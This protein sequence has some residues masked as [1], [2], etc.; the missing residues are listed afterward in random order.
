VHP[1]RQLGHWGEERA[2]AWYLKRGY[3]VI[4]RNWR[5]AQG[6]IDLL[7][8]RDG[9]LV[10]C[11]VKTRRTDH[12]GSPAEAVTR[13]KQ[14]RLRRLATAYLQV[15]PGGYDEIRFDVASVLGT[16]VTVVEG[17]F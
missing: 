4:E 10:V 1:G 6:E 14:H 9:V 2:A 16:T 8:R 5:T 15:S 11:E 7:C 17:A 13:A 12:F 3:R